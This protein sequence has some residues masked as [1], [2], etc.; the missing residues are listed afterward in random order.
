M[1]IDWSKDRVES[2]STQEILALQANA[3]DRGN[4]AVAAIC[5][6][7]LAA[8]KPVRRSGGTRS[9]SPTKILEAECSWNL[10]EFAK[11]LLFKYDLSAATAIKNSVGTKGFI[12]HKLTAKDG[13][14][15]LGGDQRTG[16][17]A[18][19]R[20][21]SYRVRN[22]PISLV[23]LLISEDPTHELV[24]Q[25]LGPERL[26]KNFKPYSEIRPYA[27][28]TDGNL[29]PGG[30]EFTDFP[31]AAAQFEKLLSQVANELPTL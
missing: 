31:E 27:S 9:S 2:L 8:R 19:D 3:R 16:K 24:W 7:V 30:E 10:A 28:N 14:A 1:S 13:N 12:A 5:E 21:I 11:Q 20:Y 15:K 25:V 23:G 18:I 29:Y 4:H 17:V 22:E 26:L 6:E